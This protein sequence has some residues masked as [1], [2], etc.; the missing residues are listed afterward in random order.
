MTP[1]VKTAALTVLTV[2]FVGL[3]LRR[4]AAWRRIVTAGLVVAVAPFGTGLYFE[5]SPAFSARMGISAGLVAMLTAL[6]VQQRY[7]MLDEMKA[8]REAS[9]NRNNVADYFD[10][11]G[12]N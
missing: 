7:R 12:Q 6:L 10:S 1:N 5:S 2:V 11:K 8:E 9:I 4:N 3:C